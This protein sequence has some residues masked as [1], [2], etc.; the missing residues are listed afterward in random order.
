[1]TVNGNVFS[2]AQSKIFD[3]MSSD[4]FVR[5]RRR[6]RKLEET[7]ATN[8]SQKLASDPM[9]SAT[10]QNSSRVSKEEEN[11]WLELQSRTT[12][13]VTSR[14]T[15][16]PN[17]VP[18]DSPR[19]EKANSVWKTFFFASFVLVLL[20]I[21]IF[22]WQLTSG[23]N[24]IFEVANAWLYKH[25]ISEYK[26]II[27]NALRTYSPWISDRVLCEVYKYQQCIQNTN[28]RNTNYNVFCLN[29]F[30]AC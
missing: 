25:T 17:A 2:E 6:R 26:I 27:T 1:M 11:A 22:C 8:C 19:N 15:T 5:F 18:L 14:S 29:R 21:R 3:L 7:T 28:A 16:R 12:S 13:M 23:S 20:G 4:P 10:T 9:D 30:R 24:L